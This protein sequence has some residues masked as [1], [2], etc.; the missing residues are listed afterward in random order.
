[1]RYDEKTAALAV[2][3]SLKIQL[4]TKKPLLSHQ[5]LRMR[6]KL[7]ILLKLLRSELDQS[8]GP[9]SAIGAA[10]SRAS[11]CGRPELATEL[12]FTTE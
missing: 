2:G 1:M 8:R 3:A 10:L 11:G 4:P 6:P 9:R 7:P 12:L 5:K